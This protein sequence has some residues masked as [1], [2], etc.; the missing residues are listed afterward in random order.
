MKM[1]EPKAI[2]SGEELDAGRLGEY[3][4]TLNRDWDGELEIRQFP[5]GFS[6][7]TY[8]LRIGDL[9]MVLR[10]PPF[11]ANVK[12]GHDMSREY[13]VMKGL[14]DTFGKVP[15]VYHYCSDP[16]IIGADFYLMERVKGVVVRGKGLEEGGEAAYPKIATAWLDTFVELHGTDVGA[17]GLEDLGRP[18]GYNRRQI[19]GWTRRY[20]KVQTEDAKVINQVI[21]WL[22]KSIPVESEHTLIHNDY[23]YD[24]VMFDPED[25][26]KVKAVLDWEMAT[27]GDPLMDFGTTISYWSEEEDL[28][29]FGELISLPTYQQGNPS[30]LELVNMYAEGSGRDLS[31]IVYYYVY[32]LFKT[33]VVVQ[34]IYYRYHHG[35]TRDKRFAGLG[36]AAKGFCFKALR[37]IEKNRIDQLF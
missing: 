35:M 16:D 2:R 24:N 25:W 34:Q 20:V 31:N 21:E 18:E 37:A 23:K 10:R 11:G 13:R 17:S 27:L 8:F 28:A 3:L 6:N 1:D 36:E 26:T 7:L 4:A 33:A 15:E 9:E 19:E 30:K 14:K 22:N 29:V 5:A 12:S 32:G